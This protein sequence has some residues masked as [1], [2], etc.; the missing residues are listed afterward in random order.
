MF[1]LIAAVLASPTLVKLALPQSIGVNRQL[2][3]SQLLLAVFFP[4]Y[5]YG[6]FWCIR[7]P[8]DAE[9]QLANSQSKPQKIPNTLQ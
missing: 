6:V 1:L 9:D 8:L 2:I 4:S 3:G 7:N 5:F